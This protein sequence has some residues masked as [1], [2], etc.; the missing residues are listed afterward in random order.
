[1]AKCA[2]ARPWKEFWGGHEGGLSGSLEA[3]LA[4]CPAPQE[5]EAVHTDTVYGGGGMLVTS[6]G[7]WPFAITRES[8]SHCRQCLLDSS[9]VVLLSTVLFII[10]HCENSLWE[11]T[12]SQPE[13]GKCPVRKPQGY[14]DDV[15]L[16]ASSNHGL[17]CVL[18]H[19]AAANALWRGR[20]ENQRLW[21]AIWFLSGQKLVRFNWRM[22]AVSERKKHFL[23][24][25]QREQKQRYFSCS[26]PQKIKFCKTFQ[27]LRLPPLANCTL[28][29]FQKYNFYF[30]KKTKH[31]KNT[32]LRLSMQNTG[33]QTIT[34]K[35]GPLK[36]PICSR[37]PAWVQLLLCTN[38]LNN[39]NAGR[40]SSVA[41]VVEAGGFAG[42]CY[43][44]WLSGLKGHISIHVFWWAMCSAEL[45][46]TPPQM[47]HRRR[48][49]CSEG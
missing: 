13:A 7:Q 27:E 19:F 9:R 22:S 2:S 45:V 34:H 16:L 17:Q 11:E 18:D 20:D 39:A 30:G 31:T 32:Q 36:P 37:P 24:S 10:F 48:R 1:M 14:A 42:L 3:V 46:P 29:S 44:D 28:L 38:V 4:N 35:V 5:G 41:P 15:S 49:C 43:G 26:G 12:L 47:S 33:N 40:H 6:T 23:T 8:G 25:N 21:F